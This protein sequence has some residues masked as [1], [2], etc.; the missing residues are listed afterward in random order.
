MCMEVWPD[1][2]KSC[3]L[4]LYFFGFM[5]YLGCFASPFVVLP[6]LATRSN[7]SDA[8]ATNETDLIVNLTKEHEDSVELVDETRIQYFYLTLG[9]LFLVVLVVF[10]GF[11][12]LW[13]RTLFSSGNPEES[14]TTEKE[15]Y[16]T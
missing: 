5:F 1:G 9:T 16:F 10:S 15:K 12:N 13:G 7:S 4:Y 3:S 11:Y 6:F 14:K 8:L 2:A